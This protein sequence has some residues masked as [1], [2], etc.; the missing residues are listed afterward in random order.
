MIICEFMKD[1]N[2]VWEVEDGKLM[3]DVDYSD[4]LKFK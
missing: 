4:K 2:F 1:F 3:F